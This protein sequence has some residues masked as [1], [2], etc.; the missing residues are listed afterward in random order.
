MSQVQPLPG[1]PP[2]PIPTA[3]WLGSAGIS[4]LFASRP[5]HPSFTPPAAIPPF[6]SPFPANSPWARLPPL[7]VIGVE[8]R[9]TLRVDR[10]PARTPWV[11]RKARAAGQ[12]ARWVAH[13]PRKHGMRGADVHASPQGAACGAVG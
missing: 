9:Q 12:A 10:V 6:N 8:A 13:S 7:E 2:H 4:F 11:R 3:P 1:V 5:L